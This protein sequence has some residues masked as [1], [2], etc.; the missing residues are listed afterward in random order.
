MPGGAWF[1]FSFELLAKKDR[2]TIYFDTYDYFDVRNTIPMHLET[3]KHYKGKDDLEAIDVAIADFSPP[4]QKPKDH[5]LLI[6]LPNA[7]LSR[8][9]I[10]VVIGNKQ[11]WTEK[12]PGNISSEEDVKIVRKY[13]N[14]LLGMKNH[15]M[16]PSQFWLFENGVTINNFNEIFNP[17]LG[18][19]KDKIQSVVEYSNLDTIDLMLYYSGEGTTIAGDKCIIPYDADKNKIHSFFKI[20]DLYSMLNEINKIDNIGD[21]FVFMDV[22]FN[23]SAFKQNLKTAEVGK[24]KKKKKKKKKNAQEDKP[25]FPLELIPPEG[26]TTFYAANTT[27]R[28]YDHPDANNGIFT[29]YMLKGLRG[30]ADNGDKVITVGELHNY[31]L[32]NVHETTKNL[33]SSLPQTPQLFT[34]NPDRVLLRLP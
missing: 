20:K 21:I 31:I 34:E 5:K 7:N 4:A 23:N 9:M 6:N 17:N 30:D 29:Y 33:Y 12:I 32:K 25:A 3:L 2:F 18:F 10:G 27:E 16:I 1:D 22:D 15:Q 19:I 24:K 26:I 28:S 11:F 13:Y 8:E 14:K